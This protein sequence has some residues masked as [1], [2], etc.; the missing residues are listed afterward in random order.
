L[1]DGRWWPYAAIVDLSR[2]A[3]HGLTSPIG[4]RLV[5]LHQDDSEISE[6]VIDSRRLSRTRYIALSHVDQVD[7]RRF[8]AGES[9]HLPASFFLVQITAAQPELAAASPRGILILEG[10]LGYLL[11]A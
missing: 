10:L 2:P 3:G 7:Y 6:L 11:P 5:Q 9:N 1:L 8:S 4:D